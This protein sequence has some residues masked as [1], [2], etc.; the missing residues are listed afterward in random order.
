VS[1]RV[2]VVLG[3]REIGDDGSHG[4]SAICRAVV[5][6]AESLAGEATTASVSSE[7]WAL[8]SA[9]TMRLGAL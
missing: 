3:Y 8:L 6:R 9:I 2:I 5:R 1:D 7:S 4:I